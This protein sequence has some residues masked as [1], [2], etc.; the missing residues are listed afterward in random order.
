MTRSSHSKPSGASQRMLRVGEL[1]RHAIVDVFIH[2]GIHDPVLET[3]TITFPE[4]KMTA[5]LRH[6]TI[7]V[8]PLG[9]KDTG[10]VIE[11]LNKHKRWLRG[12]LAKRVE[13]RYMPE[14]HFRVDERFDEADRIERL[15]HSPKVARDLKKDEQE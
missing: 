11:A 9:G 8:M 3:H 13:M 15:L 12:V 1:I 5:D 4:V 14:L 2:E 10:A 7:Y 6:A